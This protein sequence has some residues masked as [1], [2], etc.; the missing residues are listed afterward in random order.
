MASDRHRPTGIHALDMPEAEEPLTERQR[1]YLGIAEEKI[2]FV[3]NVLTSYA[4]HSTK[5]DAFTRLYNDLML[6][7][8]GLSKLRREMIAVVVSSRNRCT[9][10]LAAHG[11]AVRELSGDGEL[12]DRLVMNYRDATLDQK[13]RTMLD[14]AWALTDRPESVGEVERETL[15]GAGW[16]DRDIWDIAAV[17]A[18]FNMT[19]R[20]S[21]AIDLQPN[22]EYFGRG[23]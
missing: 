19:N 17:A 18:F 21:S 15:R 9:Y 8:S 4:W 6:G 10:C 16:S 22:G 2:G 1:A 13:D 5:F 7:D 23:A 20:M 14:F 12:A 3:P 11:A